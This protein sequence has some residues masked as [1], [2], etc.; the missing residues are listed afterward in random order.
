[1]TTFEYY[2]ESA[3]LTCEHIVIQ[4]FFFPSP[5]KP[6][7]FLWKNWNILLEKK[8]PVN[9]QNCLWFYFSWQ[10]VRGKT[11]LPITREKDLARKKTQ[12]CTGARKK[13]GSVNLIKGQKSARERKNYLWNNE[14]VAKIDF[15]GNFF[16]GIGKNPILI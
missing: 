10:S 4:G 3:Y 2:L 1:M 8:V 9:I 13:V 15:T 7:P 6:K 11:K 14:K 12:K 16:S 5:W